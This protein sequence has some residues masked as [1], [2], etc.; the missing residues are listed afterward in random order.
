VADT[1]NQ[2]L[3]GVT[4]R[5]LAAAIEV[6]EEVQRAIQALGAS[7]GGAPARRPRRKG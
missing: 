7:S 2:V 4:D 5:R 1:R 3:V 6:L